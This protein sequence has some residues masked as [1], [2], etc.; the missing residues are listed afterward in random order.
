MG[1]T[2]GNGMLCLEVAK[3]DINHHLRGSS[4]YL[5]IFLKYIQP[6]DEGI[7]SLK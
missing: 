5:A 6:D 1:I 2:G 4:R 7:E 3:P